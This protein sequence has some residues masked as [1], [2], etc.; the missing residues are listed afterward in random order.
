MISFHPVSANSQA[1]SAR[2]DHS[3][4]IIPVIWPS[5]MRILL[6]LIVSPCTRQEFCG[7]TMLPN[8][9]SIAWISS[10]ESWHFSCH[11]ARC[12]STYSSQVE[13]FQTAFLSCILTIGPA[14]IVSYIWSSARK[15][16]S[17]WANEAVSLIKSSSITFSLSRYLLHEEIQSIFIWIVTR[18]SSDSLKARYCEVFLIIFFSK[19][20]FRA[21]YFFPSPIRLCSSESFVLWT[22]SIHQVDSTS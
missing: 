2:I 12:I 22:M 16:R 11:H 1:G 10:I 7:A 8:I 18:A 17:S 9:L 20:T 19:N 14:P 21:W 3:Q 5:S 15:I 6:G 4:S 13:Y